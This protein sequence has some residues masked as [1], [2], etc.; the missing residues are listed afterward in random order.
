MRLELY[1]R[2]ED[3][4]VSLSS[5]EDNYFLFKSEVK[6]LNFDIS[7]VK[8]LKLENGLEKVI[9]R[10]KFSNQELSGKAFIKPNIMI[11]NKEGERLEF[12]LK[13]INDSLDYR[14]FYFDLPQAW[15]GGGR[16][17]VRILE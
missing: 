8:F 11:S 3:I 15:I 10:E 5:L 4:E 2:V 7:I 6:N 12:H 9:E 17:F 14:N 1:D 16:F 13:L